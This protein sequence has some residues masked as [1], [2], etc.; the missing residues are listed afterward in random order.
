M[1]AASTV[2]RP[3]AASARSLAWCGFALALLLAGPVKSAPAAAPERPAERVE[4]P[5]T[6]VGAV[7]VA[8]DLFDFLFKSNTRNLRIIKKHLDRHHP[9]TKVIDQ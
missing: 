9:Q 4:T 2:H 8:G 3:R 1:S 7:P 5:D 6:A